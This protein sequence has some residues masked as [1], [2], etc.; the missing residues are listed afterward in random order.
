MTDPADKLIGKTNCEACGSS[1]ANATY[2]DGHTHCF[3]CGA[4]VSGAPG[5]DASEQ[6][7]LPDGL[8]VGEFSPLTKRRID[9]TTCTKFGY[10]IGTY[11]GGPVQI[12][13]YY[14]KDGHIVAQ[15]VRTPNKDFFW[16]GDDSAKKK[17][18]LFGQQ[19][20][21]DGGKI[22]I[23]TEGEIDCLTV[24]MLQGN[25]YPVVSIPNGAHGAAASIAKSLDFVNS[26]ERVVLMFD[27]DEQGKNA[28]VE[29]AGLLPPGKCAIASLALKDPNEM[30]IAGRGEEVIKAMWD[31]K[32]YRPDG[33][34]DSDEVLSLIENAAPLL[35][36]ADYPFP[37]MQA[38]TR[39]ILPGQ[40]HIVTGGS[41]TGKTEFWRSVM[42][43]NL[44]NKPDFRVGVISLEESTARAALGFVGIELGM[45]VDWLEQP[46]LAPGFK[47]AWDRII[48]GRVFFYDHRGAMDL[49]NIEAKIRY[50]AVA[51]SC[52]IVVVDNLTVMVSQMDG[53]NERSQIDHMVAR[54]AKI[55]QETGVS[56][57]L[58]C[59]LKRPMGTPHEEGGET[60]LAQLRGSGGIGHFA[61]V[62]LGIERNQQ[63]PENPNQLK[64]R[65]LK[66]RNTGKTGLA[67]GAVYDDA[68]GRFVPS[69]EP[70]TAI[71]TEAGGF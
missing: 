31:A 35:P 29:V 41:G 58:C 50:L 11:A 4:H 21:R 30:L 71:T 48:R 70:I 18:G 56:I 5:E 9:E 63:D 1:D 40:I 27:N 49:D 14:D 62:A 32:T 15:K 13:D 26:F 33:I 28:A 67:G 44:K 45:R 8:I 57:M 52:K 69:E 17:A 16:V 53:D 19:L 2:A 24:S 12:A 20:W 36:V 25:R 37:I 51:N 55:V 65:I 39:G 47:E 54:F 42:Y 46:K 34:L 7:Q 10:R 3:S 66:N 60:S 22:L 68:T 6:K 38:K 23:V 43:H 64:F 59:H 61:M